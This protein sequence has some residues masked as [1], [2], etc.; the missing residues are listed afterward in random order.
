MESTVA[1]TV[2][3]TT[4]PVA[5]TT[6]TAIPS[7]TTSTTTTIQRTT[8]TTTTIPLTQEQKVVEGTRQEIERIGLNTDG[9]NLLEVDQSEVKIVEQ[10]D[11]I[12]E[13]LAEEF[14]DVVDGEVTV[15]EIE[16]LISDKNFD[17]IPDDAQQVLVQA[18]NEADQD[19][20]ETFEEEVNIFSDADYGSYVPTGSTVNVEQR[21]VLIAAGAT[22]M[23]AAAPAVGGG[24]RRK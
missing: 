16:T 13:E 1:S 7:S 24:R 20:K 3:D 6:T 18:L 5:T 4:I 2:V 14:L 15:E 19:V 9:V 21:R 23:S 8:T 22:I 11:Q 12:D 17:E 10:L